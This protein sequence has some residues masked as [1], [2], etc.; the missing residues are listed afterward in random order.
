MAPHSRNQGVQ[1]VR[2][3]FR[4]S[5]LEALRVA[6]ALRIG[7]LSPALTRFTGAGSVA[8]L[9]RDLDPHL[10]II[11][12]SRPRTRWLAS[13]RSTV[14][15]VPHVP[16]V[17]LCVKNGTRDVIEAFRAGVSDCVDDA[18]PS[19][20][21]DT[22]RRV[23]RHSADHDLMLREF[24]P[25]LQEGVTTVSCLDAAGVIIMALNGNGD[26]T[27]INRRGAEILGYRRKDVVGKNWFLDFMPPEARRSARAFFRDLMEGNGGN[28]GQAVGRIITRTRSRRVISWHTALLRNESGEVSGVLCSGEDITGRTKAH[29]VA[30][31]SEVRYRG[32]FNNM[33]SGVIV[34]GPA[35]RGGD[36]IVREINHAGERIQDVSAEEVLG[37]RMSEAFPRYVESGICEMAR[38]VRRRGTPELMPQIECGTDASIT[39]WVE[40]RM[41]RIDSGEVLAVFEDVTEQRL[42]Q[43][44]LNR[45]QHDLEKAMQRLHL[46]MEKL[47]ESEKK[48]RTLAENLPDIVQRFDAEERFIFMSNNIVMLTGKPANFYL[49]KTLAEAGYSTEEC[50]VR[51]EVIARVFKHGEPEELECAIETMGGTHRMNLR[52]MP[53]FDVGGVVKSVLCISRDVTELKKAEEAQVFAVN[54]LKLLNSGTEKKDII[55]EILAR[56]KEFTG[57]DAVAIRLKDGD[58]YPYYLTNGF[59]DSFVGFEQSLCARDENGNPVPD[60]N[61]LPRLDCLCGHVIRGAI[62]ATL[63]CF[64][65]GGSFWTNSVAELPALV[66]CA[67]LRDGCRAQGYESVALVP[68]RSFSE[69]VGLLQLCSRRRGMLT[70]AIIE[71]FEGIGSSIGIA[72][73]RKSTEERLRG[74]LREKETLLKEIHHRV[75]NNL[76]VVSSLLYLQSEYMEDPQIRDTLLITQNRIRSMALVHER[77]YRTGVLATI[78]LSDYICSLVG[79][80]SHSYAVT[81]RIEFTV[82]VKELYLDI[83]TAIPCA[84]I[85]NELVTNAIKHAFPGGMNGAVTV[86]F[87]S[88][89]SGRCRLMVSDNGVGFSEGVEEGVGFLGMQLVN[90]LVGQLG[91]SIERRDG[92][93]TSFII[94][95][96]TRP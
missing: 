63:P 32:L 47:E 77:L 16:C 75:K 83:D 30:R 21:A 34:L 19:D 53:E 11:C 25:L 72:L 12:F 78:D 49:G 79:E 68:L 3:L 91:G 58:D 55:A 4:G 67:H 20:L 23:A 29:R 86:D 62:E 40:F 48:Y 38:R 90:A 2:I 17:A 81:D 28:S 46:E 31:E 33:S 24:G 61:G 94:Q 41:Y 60:E 10:I 36:F 54:I 5:Q 82:G 9:S 85:V 26:V 69:T 52:L 70:P 50:A 59:D 42:A 43:E 13:I 15:M 76:Q 71:F 18:D 1:V 88:E 64:T 80:L 51:G 95:F 45:H 7:G 6:N 65:R 35:G 39:R 66:L 84:L 44:A 96:T 92:A 93:G 22:V 73:A 74:S 56:A 89:E 27:M 57:F 8:R 37:R 87:T 14:R